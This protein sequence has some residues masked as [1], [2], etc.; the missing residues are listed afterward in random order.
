M[1]DTSE[2]KC[3]FL[4]DRAGLLYCGSTVAESRVPFTAST[5]HL[6]EA[7]VVCIILCLYLVKGEL[8]ADRG[9]SLVT[10]ALIF[11]TKHISINNLQC[12]EL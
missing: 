6:I 10:C 4:N 8:S 9:L 12:K 1:F 11:K 7:C 5:R 3:D 2:S